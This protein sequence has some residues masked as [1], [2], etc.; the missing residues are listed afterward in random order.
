MQLT[1]VNNASLLDVNHSL[2]LNVLRIKENHEYM[3]LLYGNAMKIAYAEK[4]D[5]CN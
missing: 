1:A 5:E 4:F 3:R 2:S